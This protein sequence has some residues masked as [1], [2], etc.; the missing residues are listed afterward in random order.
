[1]FAA[2]ND[3]YWPD[4][5]YVH[6]STHFGLRPSANSSRTFASDDSEP[7]SASISPIQPQQSPPQSTDNGSPSWLSF[8]PQ[9][10][11]FISE[12]CHKVQRPVLAAWRRSWSQF[13]DHTDAHNPIA[14]QDSKLGTSNQRRVVD[15]GGVNEGDFSAHTNS[16]SYWFARLIMAKSHSQVLSIANAQVRPIPVDKESRRCST[17]N[18]YINEL[19]YNFCAWHLCLRVLTADKRALERDLACLV[20]AAYGRSLSGL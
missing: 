5:G 8:R 10:W 2:A 12:S 20:V 13:S 16:S 9:I 1:L 15:V 17:T 14:F 4:A 18:V 3:S 19:N 11:Q 7:I 6:G